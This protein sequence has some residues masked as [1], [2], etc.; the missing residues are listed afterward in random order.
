MAALVMRRSSC[1][2]LSDQVD[3]EA[4]QCLAGGIAGTDPAQDVRRP[5]QR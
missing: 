4:A 3:G 5:A 1:A 2:Y